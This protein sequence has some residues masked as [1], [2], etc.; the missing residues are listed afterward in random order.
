MGIDVLAL[1]IDVNFIRLFSGEVPAVNQ[2]IQ[3]SQP[4]KIILLR[5]TVSSGCIE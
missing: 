4:F 2:L 3:V 1:F 5:I